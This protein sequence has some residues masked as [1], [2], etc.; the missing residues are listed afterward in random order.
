MD[1]ARGRAVAEVGEAQ[2]EK[3]DD[4]QQLGEPEVATDPQVD[5]AEEQQVRGDVVGADVGCGNEVGL[6]G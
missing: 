1:S 6:V 5:E 2:V 3:V 4:E